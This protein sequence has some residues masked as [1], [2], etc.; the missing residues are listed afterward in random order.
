[1]RGVAVCVRQTVLVVVVE[2]VE[3]NYYYR[4]V[5]R[6]FLSLLLFR[7]L[8][9]EPAV[10]C[11]GFSSSL[12][13]QRMQQRSP[14]RGGI[15]L[16]LLRFCTRTRAEAARFRGGS[17][18]VARSASRARSALGAAAERESGGSSAAA[19]RSISGAGAERKSASG[20]ERAERDNGGSAS[21]A[22]CA[23][24]AEAAASVAAAAAAG[25]VQPP[26]ARSTRNADGSTA[27]LIP[28]TRRHRTVDTQ[29]LYFS[30]LCSGSFTRGPERFKDQDP[31]GPK[32]SSSS[33]CAE[34]E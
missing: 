1:M 27:L 16:L 2:V 24:R 8:S 17:A 7:L 25:S 5:F 28:A 18:S 33:R 26:G 3:Y 20:A 31:S 11:E 32:T 15:V 29:Q 22:R 6:A 12:L 30:F 34:L 21:G 4:A 10:A 13:I 9:R 14:K 23:W 19:A